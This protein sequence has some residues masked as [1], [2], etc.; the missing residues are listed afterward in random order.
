MRLL[1]RVLVVSL[2]LSASVG[3]GATSAQ[4]TVP[5]L[6]N[7]TTTPYAGAK[8]GLA[9]DKSQALIGEPVHLEGCGYRVASS[10][11][12]TM[13]S[14]TIVLGTAKA[15]APGRF[16]FQ[17]TVPAGAEIGTQTITATGV[18]PNGD[19]RVQNLSFTVAAA[20]VATTTTVAGT[21]AT[22]TAGATTP[23]SAVAGSTL[24]STGGGSIVP[25]MAGG[26]VLLGLGG[27]LVLLGRRRRQHIAGS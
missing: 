24:P 8:P 5:C 11:D 17:F 27:A 23:A 26:I 1:A 13:H 19:P 16:A 2:V 12:I 14:H 6:E 25:E 20:Q 7:G 15:I 4:E 9:A 22:T 21:T 18:D 3:V 10:V